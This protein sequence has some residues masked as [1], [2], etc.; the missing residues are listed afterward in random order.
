MSFDFRMPSITG[1]DKEQLAQLR[2]YLYQFIPQLQWAL[3]SIETSGGSNYVVQQQP[4]NAASTSTPTFDATIAFKDLKALIIKSAD[5]V[6]AYYDVISR[7]LQGV[8][9]AESDY[10][11]F[12]QQ[13]EQ[14]IKETSTYTEQQFTN[15]Q[16]IITDIDEKL[17]LYVADVEAYI[18]HGQIDEDD[19]GVPIYGIEVG[20]INTLDG[21]KEFN[22]FAR[23]TA[24]RLSFYDQNSI[25]VAYISDR[26]LYIGEIEVLVSI[27]RG[28]LKEIILSNGDI[29][30][31]WVGGNG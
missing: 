18:R 25:E 7:K 5:I 30:E 15:V 1:T 27:K 12:V 4:R 16:G 9:V 17:D 10:G 8:Y 29:V 26:R 2:S 28:G 22:A 31:K 19:K 11:T 21:N 23:F 13:T 14:S 20:Q 6:E 24:D 3:N